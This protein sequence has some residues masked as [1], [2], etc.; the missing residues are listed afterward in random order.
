MLPRM[1]VPVPPAPASSHVR[2][3]HRATGAHDAVLGPPNVEP[4]RTPTVPF[5]TMARRVYEVL[6]APPFQPT[7][8]EPRPSR[9]TG[10]SLCKVNETVERSLDPDPGT[11]QDTLGNHGF[12]RLRTDFPGRTAWRLFNAVSGQSAIIPEAVSK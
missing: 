1:H 3:P 11:G 12:S 9:L 4:S 2:L 8:S 6:R 7:A 10:E 5:S